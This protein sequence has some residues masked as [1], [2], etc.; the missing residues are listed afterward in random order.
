MRAWGIQTKIMIPLLITAVV[1]T[2]GLYYYV[3]P[4]FE[5]SIMEEKQ[6]ATRNVVELG[7]GILASY[8]A[9][10]KS[11]SSSLEEA[12]KQAAARVSQ[13]RY[14]DK[15]YLWINDLYPRMIM[16][17]FKPQLNGTDISGN[18]DPNGKRLFVEMAKVCKQQ[19][20]GFVD[21]Q[22]PKPGESV[23]SPKL[24]YVKLYEPWGWIVGSGVYL[25]DVQKQVAAVKKAVLVGLYSFLVFSGLLTMISVRVSVTRPL[26]QAIAIADCLAQGNLKVAIHAHSNDEAGKLLRAMNL[27]LEKITP[28]LR[29][30]HG[31]SMQMEQSSL[32]IS[33]ISREIEVASQAQQERARNVSNATGEL[34]KS[35]ESVR[36]LAESVRTSST[37]TETDAEQG[38]QAIQHNL[39]QTQQTVDEVSRAAQESS[40]LQ[41]VAEKIHQIVDGI[42]EISEQTH[43][44]AL[45][46]AIEAAR[47]GQQGRGFAVVAE[48]VRKLASR[49]SRETEQI[50]RIISELSR[51]VGENVNT[52]NRVV[53]RVNDG[54]KNAQDTAAVIEN[55]VTSVRESASATLRISQASE[56]Q[57]ARVQ[58][59]QATLDSLFE[60]VKDSGSKVGITSTISSDLNLVSHEILQLM[61]NFTFDTRTIVR[62]AL[63]EQRQD[64]RAE[65]GLLVTVS[66]DGHDTRA[67]GV[68]SDF[69]VS[70]LQLRLPASSKVPSGTSW[71]LDIMTPCDTFD[72]YQRQQPLQVSARVVW[73]RRDGSNT[74]YGLEFEKLSPEQQKRLEESV[75][76]FGKNA[77][78]AEAQPAPGASLTQPPD[79]TPPQRASRISAA[80]AG[81][82]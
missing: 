71:L 10:V 59:L 67:E 48:E 17:P 60:A 58:E 66:A 57:M 70:G 19:G 30:I 20:G 21:Y 23:P 12:Q 38:L 74:L 55:M 42:T 82:K 81:S 35:S 62:P 54:A 43:L 49:T 80:A 27:I 34:R 15:E 9:Q 18:K 64:P 24:S 45:N 56:S 6:A 37:A 14:D 4:I 2:A 72:E 26:H 1:M 25:D 41:S 61:G 46:A 47:A 65:N 36:D 31:A 3:F 63:N 40:A 11:G 77:R 78:F 68:T 53:T 50:A 73:S 16:H 22:W 28:I 13:L 44:L 79:R 75:R 32:E 76:Y 69:S 7:W 39:V 33:E 29:K 5:R 8:D 52:M 51:Q